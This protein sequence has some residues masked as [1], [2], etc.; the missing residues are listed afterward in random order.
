MLPRDAGLSKFHGHY[1]EYGVVL[2]PEEEI[3][4]LYVVTESPL[5]S[6]AFEPKLSLGLGHTG[7]VL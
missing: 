5:F 6:H 3:L 4:A 2:R 7:P 1:S